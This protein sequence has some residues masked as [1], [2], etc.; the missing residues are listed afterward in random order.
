[1]GKTV[2][3]YR[4]ALEAEIS[5][6]SGFAKALHREYREAFD[7]LMHMCRSHAS[8][9]SNA[10]NLKVFETIV[11]SILIFQQKRNKKLEAPFE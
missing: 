8:E 3:S 11:M 5:R 4:I 7:E 6:W 1:M 9:S 2:P 10:T